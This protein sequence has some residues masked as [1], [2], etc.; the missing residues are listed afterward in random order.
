MSEFFWSIFL[1]KGFPDSTLLQGG[2][3]FLRELF[4][5]GELFTNLGGGLFTS[6]NEI[7]FSQLDLSIVHAGLTA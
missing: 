3:L 2:G 1:T 4:T 7:I 5:K 6:F